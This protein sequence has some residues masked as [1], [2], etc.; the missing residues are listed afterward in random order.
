LLLIKN[1]LPAGY[2]L[3]ADNQDIKVAGTKVYCVLTPGHTPGSM[4]YVV[5]DEYL[6][7][8]D[9]LS[10]ENGEVQVF[11]KFF[12]MDT[13]VEKSSIIKLSKLINIR[14]IFTAHYGYADNY[15]ASFARWNGN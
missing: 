15:Q 7:S 4:S 13:N 9:T 8:G 5:N 11:N 14:Y 1:T 3:L 10:L 2:S 12:N 6:F